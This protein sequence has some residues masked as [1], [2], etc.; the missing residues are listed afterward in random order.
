MP[1]NIK[2]SVDLPDF[3]KESVSQI[4][5]LCTFQAEFSGR[6]LE[7]GVVAGGFQGRSLWSLIFSPSLCDLPEKY[8]KSELFAGFSRQV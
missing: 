3:I 1:E 4:Q 2:E 6:D 5:I 7:S 8:A